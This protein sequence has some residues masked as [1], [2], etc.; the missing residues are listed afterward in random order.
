MKKSYIL[1]ISS[2]VF[3]YLPSYFYL[4]NRH[5]IMDQKGV[6][7]T[8]SFAQYT[9]ISGH[10][11]LALRNCPSVH[12]RAL[13]RQDIYKNPCLATQDTPKDFSN[14]PPEKGY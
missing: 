4:Y 12:N 7:R 11:D 1:P 2:A 14:W 13:G 3:P 6:S 10:S 9:Q 5:G 8:H